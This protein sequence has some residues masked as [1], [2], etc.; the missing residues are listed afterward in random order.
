M[1][2]TDYETISS[3]RSQLGKASSHWNAWILIY[4]NKLKK[5]YDA[6]FL[7]SI[8]LDMSALRKKYE[9]GADPIE[10][11][12]A[13]YLPTVSRASA[14]VSVMQQRKAIETMKHM[15]EQEQTRKWVNMSL[16]FGLAVASVFGYLSY[17]K[18]DSIQA[19]KLAEQHQSAWAQSLDLK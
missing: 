18:W 17:L 10:L 4:E 2:G 9:E 8:N 11:V 7:G 15:R 13:D 12:K 16:V 5:T 1:F 14:A 3:M 6:S 19:E